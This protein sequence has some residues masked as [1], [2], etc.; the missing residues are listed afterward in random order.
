MITYKELKAQGFEPAGL[1][2]AD[3]G[4]L[5][6]GDPTYYI[7]GTK[8]DHPLAH[9]TYSCWNDFCIEKQKQGPIMIMQTPRGVNGMGLAVE[10]LEGDGQYE[11]FAKKNAAGK[12]E[13]LTILL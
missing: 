5:M 12:I 9:G 11:V 2:G 10:T 1:V 7:G 8:D 6:V 3:S 13:A 4:M